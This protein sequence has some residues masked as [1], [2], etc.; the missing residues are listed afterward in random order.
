MVE[1]SQVKSTITV[2][3][4]PSGKRSYWQGKYE[5]K[6]Y[7]KTWKNWCPLC[8]KE[9]ALSDNPKGTY[10]GEV[11]CSRK[12]GGCDADYDGVTGQDKAG[13]GSRGKLVEANSTSTDE[14]TDTNASSG[15]SASN[16]GD[17][18]LDLIKPL[19]GE[20]MALQYENKVKVCRIPNPC[21]AKLWA[22][23]GVNI[24]DDSVTISDVNPETTNK[25]YVRWTNG[26]IVVSFP[27]LI[28]RFGEKEE[29]IKAV[30]YQTV[31]KWVEDTSSTD[32]STDSTDTSND[33]DS[34]ATASAE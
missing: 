3:Q 20:V 24:V 28:E 18:I 5:Y 34:V 32:T 22:S 11:T 6:R 13:S 33:S 12:L 31:T 4:M 30:K 29:I 19:D 27:D 17:M 21:K 16:Y 7:K 8:K 2:N 15:S 26:L 25:L 1:A 10:E 14:T 23:E 9:G